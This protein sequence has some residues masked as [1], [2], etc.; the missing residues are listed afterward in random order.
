LKI[1]RQPAGCLISYIDVE[2]RAVH[3]SEMEVLLI[4]VLIYPHK[5]LVVSWK[6]MQKLVLFLWS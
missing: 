2:Y 5:L 6:L 1:E 3:S 4:Y